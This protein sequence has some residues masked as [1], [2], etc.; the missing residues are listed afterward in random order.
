MEE[1]DRQVRRYQRRHLLLPRAWAKLRKEIPRWS[2]FARAVLR[3]ALAGFPRASPADVDFRRSI[4]GPC[5]WRDKVKDECSQ[6]GCRLGGQ[7][8][9]IAKLAWAGESCPMYDPVKRPSE[10]WGAVKG[11]TIF[12]RLWRKVTGR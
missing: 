3:H 4:C 5:F 2:R 8:Q 11:E 12:R 9:L 7:K 1:R 6:C 10:Y